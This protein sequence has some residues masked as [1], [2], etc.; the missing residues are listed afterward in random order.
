MKT[1]YHI[2]IMSQYL[3]HVLLVCTYFV[4]NCML[5]YNVFNEHTQK[6]KF[7]L[8][9]YYCIKYFQNI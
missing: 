2:I 5:S 7:E 1:H 8:N 3:N 9:A 6:M 4:E